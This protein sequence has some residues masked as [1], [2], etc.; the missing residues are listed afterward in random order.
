MVQT[1]FMIKSMQITSGGQMKV[2]SLSKDGNKNFG[3]IFKRK[4]LGFNDKNQVLKEEKVNKTDKE[5]PN[6]KDK[7]ADQAKQTEKTLKKKEAYKLKKKEGRNKEDNNDEKIK[8]MEIRKRIMALAKELGIEQEKAAKLIMP[9]D[10]INIQNYKEQIENIIKKLTALLNVNEEQKQQLTE[11]LKGVIEEIF[12]KAGEAKEPFGQEKQVLA[13]SIK[14][15]LDANKQGQ[16]N[17][18]TSAEMTKTES[19]TVINNQKSNQDSKVNEDESATGKSEPVNVD[20]LANKK[21][22]SLNNKDSVTDK[23][24]EIKDDK[25]KTASE[26]EGGTNKKDEKHGDWTEKIRV[27]FKYQEKTENSFKL[28]IENNIQTVQNLQDVQVDQKVQLKA[29]SFTLSNKEQILS[30]IIDKAAVSLTPEKAEMVINLKPDHLGKLEMKIITER[31][32]MNAQIVAENQ[33]VKQIIESNFNILRDALEK[34]GIAVQNFSVSVGDHSWNRGF[35]NNEWQSRNS[36]N[37]RKYRTNGITVGGSTYLQEAS[38]SNKILWPES[39]VNYT[40]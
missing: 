13:Q 37:Q 22:D 34:Q 19:E 14:D 10:L 24:T 29:S 9:E 35:Q 39:T 32:I 21:Q 31:G 18:E 7:R 30:Q 28:P 23:I 20:K 6:I 15:L 36:S 3:E 12:S 33:Q 27:M 26:N 2:K 16:A 38:I 11:S 5:N 40:A 8:E 25:K 17:T 4:R 1:N